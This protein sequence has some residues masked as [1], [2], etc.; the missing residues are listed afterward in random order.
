MARGEACDVVFLMQ[1]DDAGHAA[2]ALAAAVRPLS[3]ATLLQDS[4]VASVSIVGQ[5]IQSHPGMTARILRTLADENVPVRL[6][7]SSA[8]SLCCV[9]PRPATARAAR[10]LHARLGLDAPGG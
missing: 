7:S 10:A 3:G 8:I 9:V 2:E 1:R 4:D 6:V 5:G